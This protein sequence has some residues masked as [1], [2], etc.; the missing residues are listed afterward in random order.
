M[1]EVVHFRRRDGKQMVAVFGNEA[2]RTQTSLA[3]VQYAERYAA[4]LESAH[5]DLPVN[6]VDSAYNAFAVRYCIELLKEI[7]NDI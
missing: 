3:G 6:L 4:G 1:I 2:R 7:R 5:H